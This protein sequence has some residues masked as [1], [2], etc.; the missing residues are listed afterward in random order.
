MKFL[1]LVLVA[2]LSVA[3]SSTEEYKQKMIEGAA[4]CN[5]ICKDNPK[6]SEYSRKAGGGI[7]LLFMG[8]ME[9]KCGC[10]KEK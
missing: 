7:P 4:S 3:C 6:I 5:A 8:G 10:S 1:L 2:S 9:E